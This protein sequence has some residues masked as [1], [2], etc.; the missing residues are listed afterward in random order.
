LVYISRLI[1]LYVHV[2]VAAPLF[3]GTMS[4]CIVLM[5]DVNFIS[6]ARMAKCK[7][8]KGWVLDIAPLTGAQ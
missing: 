1:A 4:Q 5:K 6:D 8:G 3:D 7:K 2:C